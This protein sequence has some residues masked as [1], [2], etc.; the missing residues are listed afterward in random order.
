LQKQ[1][2]KYNQKLRR[3]QKKRRTTRKKSS[4]SSP[5]HGNPLKDADV[6]VEVKGNL[7]NL[8]DEDFQKTRKAQSVSAPG[9]KHKRKSLA[10]SRIHHLLMYTK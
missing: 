1:D 9:Q 8:F 6:A 5:A 2:G 7:K 3:E 10:L 4:Q